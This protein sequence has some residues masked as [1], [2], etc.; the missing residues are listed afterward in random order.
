MGITDIHSLSHTKWNCKNHIVFVQKYRRYMYRNR[1]FWCKD[2][3][4][5]T[6]EKNADRIAGYIV[7]QLRE[8]QL[9][10]S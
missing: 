1:R 2:Y 8:D 10:N 3:Y 9:G 5:G 7:N 6:A 4:V